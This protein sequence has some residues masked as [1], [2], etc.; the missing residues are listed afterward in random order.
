M[1]RCIGVSAEG[2]MERVVFGGVRCADDNSSV[3]R[4]CCNG[5][6]LISLPDL[7]FTF[8]IELL[9]SFTSSNGTRLHFSKR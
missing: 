2:E 6:G 7:T 3:L 9:Q 1:F 8:Q 4:C 5:C